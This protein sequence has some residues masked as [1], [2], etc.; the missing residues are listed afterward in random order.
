MYGSIMSALSGLEVIGYF[1]QSKAHFPCTPPPP[2]HHHHTAPPSRP[3]CRLLTTAN[4]A[5]NSFD[6]ESPLTADHFSFIWE[7][8]HRPLMSSQR[9]A[10]SSEDISFKELPR[11]TFELIFK[12]VHSK[13]E[14]YLSKIQQT[15]SCLSGQEI[16]C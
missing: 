13:T 12:K 11:F 8:S 9:G 15:C 5:G 14:R 3:L 1:T 16:V 10:T 4:P 2:P 6:A 7:K